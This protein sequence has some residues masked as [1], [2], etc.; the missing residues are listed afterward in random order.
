VGWCNKG[1]QFLRAVVQCGPDAVGRDQRNGHA[2]KD[3][4]P[5]SEMS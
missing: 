5:I 3:A 2:N 4:K 1:S